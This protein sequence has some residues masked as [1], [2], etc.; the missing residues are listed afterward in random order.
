MHLDFSFLYLQINT[1]IIVASTKN[2]PTPMEIPMIDRVYCGA[3]VGRIDSLDVANV[4]LSVV[5]EEAVA[6]GSLPLVVCRF[7]LLDTGNLDDV[8]VVIVD[9]PAMTVVAKKRK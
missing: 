8:N 3:D 2:V 5:A 6:T 1:V 4:R 7:G 9:V